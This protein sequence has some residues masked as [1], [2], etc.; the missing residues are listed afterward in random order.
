[1][2][3]WEYPDVEGILHGEETDGGAIAGGIG[4]FADEGP[5]QLA[6]IPFLPSFGGEIGA[7][8][9]VIDPDYMEF[10]GIADPADLIRFR[11]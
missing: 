7:D 9:Y 4:A 11:R 10:L 2:S 3:K 6:E 1:M 5:R 8:Q